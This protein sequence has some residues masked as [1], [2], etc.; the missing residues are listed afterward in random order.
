L[1]TSAPKAVQSTVRRHQLFVVSLQ[2]VIKEKH[3]VFGAHVL[4]EKEKKSE[5]YI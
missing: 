2:S 4:Y 5:E 1:P 3:A